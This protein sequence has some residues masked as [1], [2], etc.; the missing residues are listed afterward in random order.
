LRSLKYAYS[1]QPSQHRRYQT[2]DKPQF[3]SPNINPHRKT[4]LTRR[5]AMGRRQRI[6][7]NQIHIS[8][9]KTRASG[10]SLSQGH[11]PLNPSPLHSRAEEAKSST[12]VPQAPEGLAVGVSGLLMGASRHVNSMT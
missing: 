2:R 3:T 6:P 5:K 7:S 9:N 1:I 10:F 12:G 4:T 8:K 11:H